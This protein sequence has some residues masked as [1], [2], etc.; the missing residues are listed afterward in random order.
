MVDGQRHTEAETPKL[1][2][3]KAAIAALEV[4]NG[5]R[6][7]DAAMQ[8]ILTA[9]E[10][11]PNYRLRNSMILALHRHAVDK[12]D[13][14]AGAFRPGDVNISKSQHV[15]PE[16]ALVP[17]LMEEMCDFVNDNWDMPPVELGAYVLWRICWIHPFT[18]GNG[19]TAR[20]V[21][22]VV[23]CVA[24]GMRLP[25]LLSIPEQIA[26]NKPPY[27]DALEAA[28]AIYKATGR[29]DVS[30]LAELIGNMLAKQLATVHDF[31][32]GDIEGLRLAE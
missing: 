5:V 24:I 15:P 6:Q 7:F 29:T 4:A 1:V 11:K 32:K 2:E 10:R 9:I 8:E 25:G 22:Y 14:F 23:M 16:A 18:D 19:R 3:D 28:D 17:G 20:V 12:L 13:L 30:E 31:A 26:G 27:Y 21:S